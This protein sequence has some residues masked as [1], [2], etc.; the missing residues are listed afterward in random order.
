MRCRP[1]A[2][3]TSQWPSGAKSP[4]PTKCAA[5]RH[6]VSARLG[7]K[8]R[9]GEATLRST[10]ARFGAVGIDG[11]HVAALEGDDTPPRAHCV[12]GDEMGVPS[13]SKSAEARACARVSAESSSRPV[14][15]HSSTG[16]SAI[17]SA[18]K[19]R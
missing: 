15:A 1:C 14:P 18:R 13:S 11:V 6:T 5:S 7:V 10:L 2:A 16:T 12:G 9:V 3:T 8:G 17:A 4:A 19:L